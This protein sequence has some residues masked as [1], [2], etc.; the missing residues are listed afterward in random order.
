MAALLYVRDDS[1]LRDQRSV[2]VRGHYGS[3][4]CARLRQSLLVS[5]MPLAH[6]GKSFFTQRHAAIGRKSWTRSILVYIL[7]L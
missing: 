4:G 1:D 5:Y 3:L 7:L 2:G 6:R